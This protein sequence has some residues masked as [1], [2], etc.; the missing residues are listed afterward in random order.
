MSLQSSCLTGLTYLY[1]GSSVPLGPH[2][3]TGPW[4]TS[5]SFPRGQ[6]VSEQMCA[7]AIL[8][9]RCLCCLLASISP[10]ASLSP[11]KDG[12][13]GGFQF[14][15]TVVH[16]FLTDSLAQGEKLLCLQ[17]PCIQNLFSAAMIGPRHPRTSLE[18]HSVALQRLPPVL[19]L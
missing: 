1:P 16:F 8:Q 6:C 17:P 11:S 13:K 7:K 3:S 4:G 19:P 9:R 12:T 2:Y 5:R 15:S 14:R 18:V 10:R